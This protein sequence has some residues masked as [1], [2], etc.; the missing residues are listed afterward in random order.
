M[1]EAELRA[2]IKSGS[3]GGCY[4]LTG[5]EDYLKRYYLGEIRR[6][7]VSDEAFALFNHTV[8]DGAVV[9]F[10]AISD[11]IKSPPMMSDLKL[12]E[13][14]YPSFN[15]MKSEDL[16]AFEKVLSLLAESGN[17]AL[18][19]LAEDGE[20]DL[21]TAKSPGR[22]I[23][24]FGED[25]S[26]VRLDKKTLESELLPWLKRHFESENVKA[27]AETMRELLFRSGHNLSVLNEEVM[28]LAFYV[29]ENGRD[30]VTAEDVTYIASSTPECDTFAFSNAL[31]DR[32]KRGAL[33]A[34]EEMKRRR[35]DPIVI[36]GMM[37]KTLTELATVRVMLED[38][39]SQQDIERTMKLSPKRSPHIIRAAK[40]FSSE[41]AVRLIEELLR[42]DTGS[43]FGGVGG[44]TAIELFITKWL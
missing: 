19:F 12:I 43:K 34:L 23:K 21:G 3:L 14:K 39:M 28:K 6:A 4:I 16:D 33:L 7:V 25:I 11:D 32:N 42:V 15:K 36:M 35:V 9:D 8:Y 22:I 1:T 31:S 5:E 13:W 10:A 17:V 44:Y 41:H 37:S 26:I 18:V 40:R 27:D 30:T 24:R 20:P 38:G 2:K 29:K